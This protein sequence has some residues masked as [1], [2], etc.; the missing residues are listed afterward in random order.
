M[1]AEVIEMARQEMEKTLDAFKHEL[2]RVRTGRASTALI[3]NLRF[4][5][6]GAKPPS[7]Q[8]ASLAA[9]EPRLLVITP[10][11]KSAM[12]EIEKSIQTSD[13]GLTP[14]NDGKIIR[15]PIPELTQERRKELVKHIRKQ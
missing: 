6:Y 8:L 7:R 4:S 5:Y 3:E 1:Q 11:D 15:I 12:H 13:L 14:Q 10:Y 9:P 2:A